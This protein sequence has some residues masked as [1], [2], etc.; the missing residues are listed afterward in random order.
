MFALSMV[1][2]FCQ[3]L[4]RYNRKKKEGEGLRTYLARRICGEQ[5]QEEEEESDADESVGD[6]D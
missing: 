5:E 3:E 6:K 4:R 2:A 1:A